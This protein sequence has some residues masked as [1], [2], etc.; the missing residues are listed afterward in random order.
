MVGSST[1][2]V[3]AVVVVL[4]ALVDAVPAARTVAGVVVS[5]EDGVDVGAGPSRCRRHS[6]SVVAV[7][8]VVLVVGFSVIVVVGSVVDGSLADVVDGEQS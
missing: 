1:G 2:N 8:A 6:G 3:D 4:D 5:D 7:V